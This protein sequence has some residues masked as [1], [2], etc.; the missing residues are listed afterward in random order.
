MVSVA[1]EIPK[2]NPFTT[3]IHFTVVINEKGLSSNDF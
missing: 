1:F 2:H 3:E